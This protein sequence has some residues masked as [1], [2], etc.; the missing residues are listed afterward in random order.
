M[1]ETNGYPPFP[2]RTDDEAPPEKSYSEADPDSLEPALETCSETLA[3]ADEGGRPPGRAFLPLF[4]ARPR[5][6]PG[7]PSRRWSL[8]GFAVD[9]FSLDDTGLHLRLVDPRHPQSVLARRRSAVR[10]PL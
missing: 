2:D 7:L 5:P 4:K 1:T 3:A 8:Q 6:A 10:R 9:W